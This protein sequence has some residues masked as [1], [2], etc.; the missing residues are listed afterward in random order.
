MDE[1]IKLLLI[2]LEDCIAGKVSDVNWT[3]L[4]SNGDFH[5]EGLPPMAGK[6]IKHEGENEQNRDC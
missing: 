6:H 4:Y 5:I 2:L 1:K 3:V